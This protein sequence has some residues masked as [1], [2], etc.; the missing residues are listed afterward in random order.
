VLLAGLHW[1]GL[2]LVGASRG[3]NLIADV[4]SAL[5]LIHLLDRRVVSSTLTVLVFASFPVIARISVGGMEPAVLVSLALGAVAAG[6]AGRLFTCGLLAALAC[7]IRPE[8]VLLVAVLFVAHV[9]SP[10][11]L[12]RF[13]APVAAVGL[14]YAGAL[15]AVYGSPIPQ[16][17]RAKADGGSYP[18]HPQRVKDVLAQAFGPTLHARPLFPLVALGF[19][20]SLWTPLRTFV[21]FSMLMVAGY[22]ASGAKTWGW[23][24]YVPLTTWAIGAGLGAELLFAWF[25]ERRLPERWAAGRLR[26]APAAAALLGVL[27]MA[28]FT[29]YFPDRVTGSVYEPM[30]AWA[31]AEG[32][33]E[34]GA[35]VLASDIGA[36]GWFGGVILDTEGLVWPEGG[37]FEEQVDAVRAHLPDYVVLTVT[38]ERVLGFTADPVFDRY[39]PVRR[40]NTV[41]DEELSPP[42]GEL[43]EWW[44]QDYLVFE[45]IE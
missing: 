11:Q 22:V 33:E 29:R 25:V 18:F 38:R 28:A 3:L 30:R 16:S 36:I 21:A 4:A 2:G 35:S 19:L 14:L 24:Y 31:E 9:R 10:A 6:R 1:L 37:Q 5:L 27:A 12:L 8:A 17:V 20:C 42:T 40:F 45:R 39:R 32:L 43:P 34:R 15:F 7:T 26:Y 44:E 13:A 23:Y 41:G